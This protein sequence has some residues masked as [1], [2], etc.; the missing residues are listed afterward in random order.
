MLLFYN[1][2]SPHIYEYFSVR[3]FVCG[4][5]CM[6]LETLGLA[7]VRSGFGM[8]WTDKRRANEGN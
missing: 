3:D 5:L 8:K 1:I 2:F 6:L 4:C 7:Q